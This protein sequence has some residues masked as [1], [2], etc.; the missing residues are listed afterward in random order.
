MAFFNIDRIMTIG[1]NGKIDETHW[2][3]SL[4]SDFTTI[5][6]E[7]YNTDKYLRTWETMFV[8]PDGTPWSGDIPIYVRVRVRFGDKWTDFKEFEPCQPY[9]NLPVSWS[10]K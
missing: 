2:Q 8:L 3:A 9:N 4:D 6:K 10:N 1:V 7:T 5:L